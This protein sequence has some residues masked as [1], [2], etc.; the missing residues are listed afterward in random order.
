ML[1]SPEVGY[2]LVS[3]GCLDEKGFEANFSGGKCTITGP[4][5]RRVGM[6]P[7]NNR[8]LYRI[9]HESESASVAEE[10][11]MLDQ[12]H[13]RLGHIAVNVAKKLTKDG[14]ITGL[15]LETTP[16]GNDFFCE[17]CVYAKATCKPVAK[18]QSGECATEFGG[19]VHSDLWG[20]APVATRGGKRYYITFVNNSTRF[21]HLN[22]LA[23]KSEAQ[24]AYKNFEA[25]C[26]MQMK[27]P[28]QIL[29]S[30]HSGEYMGKEFVLYLKSKGT[31]QKLMVHNTPEENGVAEQHNRTIVK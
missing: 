23:A 2:T 9:D 10:V 17:S 5:G 7:K 6:V 29:H 27:K 13:R 8:G 22:L 12:M 25:W 28:V 26:E 15:Q 18:A 4:D 30:D 3:I 19:E 1:Y 16:S 20:L 21:T 31:E 14:F 11:L 24:G